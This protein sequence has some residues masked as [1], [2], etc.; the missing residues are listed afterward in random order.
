MN[1][2]IA[3]SNEIVRV[4]LRTILSSVPAI[5]IVG[6]SRS[7]EELINQVKNF[8]VDLVIIDYTSDGFSIDVIPKVLRSKKVQ[9]VAI[10]PEQSPNIIVDALRSGV[11]SYVKKD[12]ST[13]EII[14][15][16]KETLNGGRFFCG[17]VL[18]SIQRAEIDIDDL[19]LDNFSCEPVLLSEREIE[20]IKYVAEGYTN[21]EIAQNLHLSSHTV[22]THRKN[23]MAKLGTKNTAGIVIYAIKTGLIKPNKFLFSPTNGEVS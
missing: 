10:T 18:E 3:D 6:E 15:S 9:F 19:D 2:L 5:S 11:N 4:G 20:V 13:G 8:Q 12:C 17:Q 14:E 21:N 23:I 22:T 1:I 7:D 16:I